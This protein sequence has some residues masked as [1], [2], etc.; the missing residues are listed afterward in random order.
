MDVS[1][2][3][4]RLADSIVRITVLFGSARPC[5]K[6]VYTRHVID[7]LRRSILIWVDGETLRHFGDVTSADI[8]W[9]FRHM[10]SCLRLLLAK[11]EAAFPDWEVA[12]AF[13]VFDAR[14]IAE[15]KHWAID[16]HINMIRDDWQTYLVWLLVPCC[17]TI[18]D[19][20]AAC[21]WKCDLHN[22]IASLGP[23]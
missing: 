16:G 15:S 6:S 11:V 12:Q 7:T 19:R 13:R 22:A 18:H 9:E 3:S 2:P 5:V 20:R 14:A 4:L 23:L 17:A 1:Q 8:D 21:R 10:A